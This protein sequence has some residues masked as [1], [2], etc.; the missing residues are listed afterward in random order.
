MCRG[1]PAP[2][3]P[4][5]AVSGH[6]L[7]LFQPPI[8]AVCGYVISTHGK[9]SRSFI[10]CCLFFIY[11]QNMVSR[12]TL[13]KHLSGTSEK[14]NGKNY[15]LWSQSFETFVV[16]HRKL[17]HFTHPPPDSKDAAYED[18][19]ADD[20]A[21]V[22]W[23]GNSMESAVAHGVMLLRPAKKIWDTCRLTYGH[24]KNIS[25]GFEVYE[26][27]FTLH[28]GDRF[29]QEHFTLLRALLDE[30]EMYQ[31]LTGNVSQMEGSSR[32]CSGYLSLQLEF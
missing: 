32:A 3:A 11:S 25:R 24:E 20:A 14:L 31:P 1:S 22:S 23:L 8:S 17:K 18:W 9:Q 12:D 27:L 29:V 10:V 28:Q 30:L 15:L 6:V 16:A 13:V 19:C 21:I 5:F 2:P 26:Q 7:G 4:W